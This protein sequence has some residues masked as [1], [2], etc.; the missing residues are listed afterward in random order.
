MILMSQN[1]LLDERDA[2]AFD[3]WYL[4]HLRSMASVPGIY[5]AQRFKT[6]TPG[7]PR[8][9]ALYSVT[10][11]QAFDTPYYRSVQGM[12]VMA[13]RVDEGQHH[14]NLFEGL[15]A[16]PSV[17]EH[18]R[19]LLADRPSRQG[20]IAGI[21]FTWLKCVA[22]DFSTPYRGIAVVPADRLPATDATVAVYSSATARLSGTP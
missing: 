12:G 18:E 4:E 2:Q 7:F 9:L 6:S 19:L 5:S 14:V 17:G 10:S 21:A 11:E 8:S 16:A 3:A 1:Q 13:S 20:E 22:R 15:D